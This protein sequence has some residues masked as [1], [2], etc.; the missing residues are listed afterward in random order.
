MRFE[1]YHIIGVVVEMTARNALYSNA[2]CKAAG[3]K[4]SW[5]MIPLKYFGNTN[6]GVKGNVTVLLE[7]R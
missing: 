4:I 1:K 2:P 5:S 3:V 6:C 7:D